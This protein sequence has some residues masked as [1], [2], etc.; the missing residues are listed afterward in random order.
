MRSNYGD[1][2]GGGGDDGGDMENGI[3]M[4]GSNRVHNH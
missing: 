1:G 2:G 3:Q 4:S